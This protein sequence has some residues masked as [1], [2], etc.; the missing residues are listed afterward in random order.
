MMI[1]LKKIKENYI[2]ISILILAAILRFYHIDFQSIW[3]DEI[4]TMNEANPKLSFLNVY[5]TIMI[6][7]Q[8][9][10][11]Y[12]YSLYFLF[13]IFGYYTIVARLYSAIIAIVSIYAIYLLGKE[14]FNKKIGLIASIILCVNPFHLYYSQEARPYIFLFL[15]T[16]LSFYYL[17]KFIKLPSRKGAVLYGVISALMIYSHFFGLFVLCAQYLLLLLFLILSKKEERTP[18][19]I[20]ALISGLVALILFIPAIKIFIKVS[21]IK[22]FWI[23]APTLDVYTLIFK[24]FFGNSETVLTLIGLILFVYFIKIS[25]EK[26]ISI[27][28]NSIIENKIIFSFIILVPTIVVVLLIPLIRSYLSIPMIISRYFITVLPLIIILIS[29]GLYQFK[30]KIIQIGILSIFVIFS[31]TDILVVKKYYRNPNKTQFR[32]VTNFIIENNI[33]KE[34][35]VTSLGWYLPYFFNKNETQIIDKSLEDYVNKIKQDSTKR[36]NF[37]YFDA[38]NRP[39][40]I[41]EQTQKYLDDNFIIENN[42]DLYDAWTKHYVR[43]T[44]VAQTIDISIYNPLKASNGDKINFAVEKYETSLETI[45]VSGWAYFFNQDAKESEINILLIKDGK[46]LKLQNQKIKRDDVT[47]YFKSQYDLS[48]S[49]FYAKAVINKLLPGKYQLGIFIKNKKTF[50][51][52]LILT[53]KIFNK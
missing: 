53:D 9:P 52:G 46:A 38:H 1:T 16:T 28:Y 4:H 14:M 13:K 17:I 34:P 42:I 29:I 40:N 7:E 15:F 37:W 33:K 27:S 21:Q 3:L 50:K 30:N 48:N 24:E 20:N 32:E 10:P 2:L 26:H 39:L 43:N 23:P 5:D 6:G 35:V 25:K 11:L 22:E 19:F 44:D 49:G 12:F 47:S 45:F 18:F 31:L 8:M 51:Q 36:K 41:N